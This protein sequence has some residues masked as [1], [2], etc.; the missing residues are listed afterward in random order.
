M[1]ILLFNLSFISPS[2]LQDSTASNM[3]FIFDWILNSFS[4]VLQFLGK[5]WRVLTT[6]TQSSFSGP[7]F[8]LGL[9]FIFCVSKDVCEESLPFL[10]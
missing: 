1:D 10:V 5:Y 6:I 8:H 7:L 2:V 9:F 4:N 3:S